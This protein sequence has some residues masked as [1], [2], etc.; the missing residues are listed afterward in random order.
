MLLDA[1]LHAFAAK[2]V[3]LFHSQWQKQI[4]RRAVSA[5]RFRQQ[6][7]RGNSVDIVI[8]EQNDPLA[9][10]Q[11][12]ENAGD[13]DFHTWE[14]EGIAQGLK[15]RPEESL[16]LIAICET[17]A[18]K[19]SGDAVAATDFVPR[20]RGAIERFGRENNPATLHWS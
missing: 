13:G 15:L 12:G 11:R 17:F 14:Q 1:T 16:N 18:Q 4:G 20:D 9:S 6:R 5:Q 8:A 3:A 7:E 10:I 19:Q 2:P